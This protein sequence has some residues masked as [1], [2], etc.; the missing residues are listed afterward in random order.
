MLTRG[1]T[2]G[3]IYNTRYEELAAEIS[4]LAIQRD[5]AAGRLEM[6]KKSLADFNAGHAHNLQKLAL[7]DERNAERHG[8]P[9][10]RRTGKAET[11]A[12]QSTQPE[13]MAGAT[14][15]YSQLLTLKARLSQLTADFGAE[16]PEVKAIKTADR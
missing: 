13:R 10:V 6:V 3:D 15:E 12:F 1:T 4:Q 8:H 7:I 11:A 5:E 16:Y 14:A 9:G 2:G